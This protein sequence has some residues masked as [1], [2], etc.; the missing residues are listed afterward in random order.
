MTKEIMKQVPW[1]PE[2]PIVIME[3]LT[4]PGRLTMFGEVF[5]TDGYPI[6]A[7]LELNPK[8]GK[9]Y[10]DTLTIVNAYTKKSVKK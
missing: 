1:I 9:G 4:V 3:S 6:L 8:G 7:V 5:G 2:R 10:V